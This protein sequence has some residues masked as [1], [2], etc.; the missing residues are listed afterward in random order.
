MM[1][2]PEMIMYDQIVELEIATAEEINLVWNCGEYPN[3]ETC[4]NRIVYS[5]TGYRSL[6]Q[7]FE[8]MDEDEED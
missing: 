6:L 8:A 3:W 7:L 2:T 5:R 4:L 1:T